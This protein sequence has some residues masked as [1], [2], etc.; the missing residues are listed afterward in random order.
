V[1]ALRDIPAILLRK[2]VDRRLAEQFV[3]HGAVHVVDVVARL[4]SAE[5]ALQRATPVLVGEAMPIALDAVP[6]PALGER[7]D[8]AAVPVE[9]RPPG[10]E[11]QYLDVAHSRLLRPSRA[12]AQPAP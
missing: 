1:P 9:D 7:G 8:K 3:E 6:R 10:I 2:G 4:D 12:R 5:H 11:G